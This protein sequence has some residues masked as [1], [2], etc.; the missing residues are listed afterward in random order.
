[1]TIAAVGIPT[2]E[3]VAG[4]AHRMLLFVIIKLVRLFLQL[5]RL[6]YQRLELA[7]HLC[8]L[9][10]Y[11]GELDFQVLDGVFVSLF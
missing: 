1:V 10:R 8:F 3:Q 6:C 7:L 5:S 4:S 9:L 11:G 2:E